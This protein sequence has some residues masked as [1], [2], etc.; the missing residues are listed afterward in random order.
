MEINPQIRV[1][2]IIIFNVGKMKKIVVEILTLKNIKNDKI[3]NKI[4]HISLKFGI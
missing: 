3:I 4:I 1:D 2:G